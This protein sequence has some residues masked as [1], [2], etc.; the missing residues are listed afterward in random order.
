MPRGRY[1]GERTERPISSVQTIR[2]IGVAPMTTRTPEAQREHSNSLACRRSTS[3]SHHD[4]HDLGPTQTAELASGGY[5]M[6][7]AV[8]S[9]RCRSHRGPVLRAR[10]RASPLSC[11]HGGPEPVQTG[12]G[13]SHDGAMGTG[14]RRARAP[15]RTQYPSGLQSL[16]SVS[17][18]ERHD[19]RVQTGT[20]IYLARGCGAIDSRA[21]DRAATIQQRLYRGHGLDR[22]SRRAL[23]LLCR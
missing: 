5:G 13:A 3:R 14:P 6:A 16:W 23:P 11:R 19:R 9:A 21:A 1:V 18:C 17:G 7:P 8:E 22:S 10:Y 20:G 4:R 15:R 2:L 12:S